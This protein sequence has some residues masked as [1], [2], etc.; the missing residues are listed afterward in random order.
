MLIDADEN[1]VKR[2][3]FIKNRRKIRYDK[4]NGVVVG[5]LTEFSPVGRSRP[6][7]CHHQAIRATPGEV[8]CRE[9]R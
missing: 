6:C 4:K 5:G 3:R 9:I 1:I 7:A 8:V 2:N